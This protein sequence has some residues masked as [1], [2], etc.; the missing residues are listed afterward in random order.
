[1]FF[2]SHGK[3]NPDLTCQVLEYNYVDISA[4]DCE[5]FAIVE[6]DT[7]LPQTSVLT[8]GSNTFM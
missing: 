1:M 2:I 5:A 6:A 3:T 7:L 4:T 8:D